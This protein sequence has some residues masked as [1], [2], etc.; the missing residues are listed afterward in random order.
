[1]AKRPLSSCFQTSSSASSLKTRI[2]IGEPFSMFFSFSVASMRSD[3]GCMWRPLVTGAPPPHP[4]SVICEAIAVDARSARRR[5]R[6]RVNW[7]CKRPPI[8][9]MTDASSGVGLAQGKGRLAIDSASVGKQQLTPPI[10][11]SATE[12]D[13]NRS[14]PPVR[15]QR[16]PGASCVL[17]FV[18]A[19][20]PEAAPSRGKRKRYYYYYYYYY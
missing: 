6:E 5:D 14:S 2:R 17:S 1:S 16:S 18:A 9:N 20:R 10:P 8:P 19:R 12:G 13:T 4:A 3:R 11:Q 15:P 7:E